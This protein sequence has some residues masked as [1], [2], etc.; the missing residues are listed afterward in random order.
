MPAEPPRN[1][2]IGIEFEIGKAFPADEILARWITALA[3]ALNDL[4]LVHR[5][6]FPAIHNKT[7]DYANNYLGRLGAAHL[8]EAAKFLSDSDRIQEVKYFIAGLD[9]EVQAAYRRLIALETEKKT[10]GFP[11]V[12]FDARNLFFHYAELLPHAPDHEKLRAALSEHASTIGEIQDE[13]PAPIEGFRARFADDVAIELSYPGEKVDLPAFMG[14]LGPRLLDF[15][16]FGSAAI[17]SYLGSLPGENW[18]WIEETRLAHIRRM[19]RN[20]WRRRM[21][22][23]ARPLP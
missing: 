21:R 6:L 14:E 23:R 22:W 15:I 10:S 8:Y 2:R 12:L 17:T 16:N 4:L 1:R 20:W 7:P 19:V 5:W 3:M 9:E 11:G 18:D 13:G